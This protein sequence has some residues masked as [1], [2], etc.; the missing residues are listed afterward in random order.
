MN[1]EK[2]AVETVNFRIYFKIIITQNETQYFTY[3]I[4]TEQE[5]ENTVSPEAR[6]YLKLLSYIYMM[7]ILYIYNQTSPDPT[8]RKDSFLHNNA[9][10]TLSFLPVGSVLV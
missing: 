4:Y 5:N 6:H 7:E 2:Q 1:K 9:S 8:S 3:I 10:S